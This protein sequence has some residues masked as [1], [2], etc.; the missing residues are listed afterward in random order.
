MAIRGGANRV[1]KLYPK[2][3]EQGCCQ[4]T[5]KNNE[6]DMLTPDQIICITSKRNANRFI[7]IIMSSREGKV[8]H[9]TEADDRIAWEATSHSM[10]GGA[11]I[12]MGGIA[13]KL[14]QSTCAGV[15]Y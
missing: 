10:P 7:D 5:Q 12:S 6:Y 1:T 3:F 11:T 14:Q 9:H 4:K 13:K 8:F 15:V 2:E